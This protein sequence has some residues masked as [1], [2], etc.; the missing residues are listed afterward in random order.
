MSQYDMKLFG[1]L[2]GSTHSV[3]LLEDIAVLYSNVELNTFGFKFFGITPKSDHVIDN[4]AIDFVTGIADTMDEI[5]GEIHQYS[6]NWQYL[7]QS[8]NS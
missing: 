2:L 3:D 1:V 6:V 4:I 7:F 5:T 8:N